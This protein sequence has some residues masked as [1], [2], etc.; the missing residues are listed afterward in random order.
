ML[1]DPGQ[2]AVIAP[3][4]TIDSATAEGLTEFIGTGPYKFVEWKSDQYV[5][6]SKF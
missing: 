6:L 4:S 2:A 5:L 3:K 1:A